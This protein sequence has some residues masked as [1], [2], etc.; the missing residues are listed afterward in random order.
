MSE[1]TLSTENRS[2]WIRRVPWLRMFGEFAV[3]FLGITLSLLADDWRQSRGDRAAERQILAG[4]VVDLE[5]DSVGVAALH[6]LMTRHEASAMWLYQRNG[7]A[8]LGTDSVGA[9]LGAIHRLNP[10][11]AQRASYSGLLSTGQLALVQDEALRRQIV[12]YFENFQTDVTG[13]YQ[14]YFDLWHR[15]RDLAGQDFVWIYEPGAENFTFGNGVRLT[16][17]WSRMSSSPEFVYDLREVG[18]AAN[19]TGGLAAQ[20]LEENSRLRA[21]IRQSLDGS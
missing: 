11:H 12:G 4:L 3:I 18:I 21:A 8:G 6:S 15:F 1:D 14:I 20:A 16:R 2:T 5:S 13:F 17:P 9:R 10:F 19:V 7:Q